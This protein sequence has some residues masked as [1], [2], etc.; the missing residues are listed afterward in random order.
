MLHWLASD[1]RFAYV[2]LRTLLS[3]LLSCGIVL[4]LGAPVIRW[5]RQRKIGDNPDFDRADMNAIMADKRGTPTMGG[6]LIL[7][8]I[9]VSTLLLA[10]L[11]RVHAWLAIATLLVLGSLGATDDWL[12][13]NKHRRAAK[14]GSAASRQGLTGRQKLIVQITFGLLVAWL[15]SRFGAAGAVCVPFTDRSIVLPTWAYLL[16]GA[17]V[18]T[19]MSNSVNLTDGLD[20][21][22]SGCV[23]IAACVLV[24][25]AM[26]AADAG[27]AS[28]QLA[29]IAG[30]IGGACLGFLWFN[31][32]PARVF[33]GDTG[34]LALGG[35]LGVV[36]L[37][38]RQELLLAIVGAVFVAEA[39][40]VLLQV[41]YF[42]YTRIR[43][44][45]GLRIFRMSPLHHHFQKLGWGESQ[46]VVRF[47]VVAALLAIIGV[48]SLRLR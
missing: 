23:A 1:S 27:L 32:N 22:S 43:F 24:L 19:A 40:S 42:K 18:L 16:W 21:L 2:T 8:A 3:V 29:V 38:L 11:S 10:D 12:K 20:G 14:D 45:E 9:L 48:A 4:A 13:L 6:V 46:V 35:L 25:A 39:L 17:F 36:A 41:Y 15:L 7:A 44:G 5:L 34:S 30:A 33:M 31:A 28:G 37:S 47:W 26:V